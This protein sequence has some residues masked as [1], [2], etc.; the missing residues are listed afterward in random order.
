MPGDPIYKRRDWK[1]A[2]AYW[3][4]E[5]RHRGLLCQAPI[6]VAPPEVGRVIH[7]GPQWGLDVGHIVGKALARVAGWSEA[8][9]NARSNTR[10]EH[11]RCNRKAGGHD[12]ARM[13][14][15]A[16]RPRTSLN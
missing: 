16:N 9:I 1:D 14:R 2:V 7:H 12:G 15:D 3:Q 13:R 11:R 5:H 10:P 4:G 6:C 8:Q